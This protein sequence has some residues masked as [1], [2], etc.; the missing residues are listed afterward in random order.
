MTEPTRPQIGHQAPPFTLPASTGGAVSLAEF[1]GERYVV[2]YFYPKDDTSGCTTEACSFRDLS[3]DF[4]EVDAVILGVSLDPLDSHARFASKHS[5]PFP[6]LA[7]TDAAVSKA[8]GVYRQKTSFGQTRWGI[9]RTTFV[10]DRHGTISQI[11][12]RVEV[13]RHAR[14]VLDFIR[15]QAS[16]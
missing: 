13:E 9:E 12:P 8:Y 2:L 1:R 11:Y 10:M 7:D 15:S 14:Q 3:A 5:L 6:L 4:A 16:R